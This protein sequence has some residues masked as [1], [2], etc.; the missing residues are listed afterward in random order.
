MKD[1][2]MVPLDIEKQ[3]SNGGGTSKGYELVIAGDK[4]G[5]FDI[6]EDDEFGGQSRIP[7]SYCSVNRGIKI[8]PLESSNHSVAVVAKR[9]WSIRLLGTSTPFRMTVYYAQQQTYMDPGPL[10]SS[11]QGKIVSNGLRF[12]IGEVPLYLKISLELS[13]G[14]FSS[15]LSSHSLIKC[16]VRDAQIE[17]KAKEAIWAAL[18]APGSH[19]QRIGRLQGL[20]IDEDLRLAILEYL[21]AGEPALY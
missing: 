19:A 1:G 16:I 20:A 8:G 14:S 13:P 9:K 2:A 7:V 10:P 15:N 3:P 6:F 17:Y 11:T 4:D 18:G 5:S 21:M 12:E